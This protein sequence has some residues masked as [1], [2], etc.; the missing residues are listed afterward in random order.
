MTAALGVP[1]NVTVAL[2]PEQIVAFEEIETIGNGSMVITTEPVCGKTQLG[3]P[4]VA[5]LTKLKVV[6]VAYVLVIV[7]T[8]A[9]FKTIV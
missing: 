7:A 4:P 8:P 5:I 6:V 2:A 3:T 9:A 1:V